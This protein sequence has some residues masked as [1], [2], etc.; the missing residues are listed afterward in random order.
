MVRPE[1]SFQ[2]SVL[3]FY[4]GFWGP[5]FA[6]QASTV[7]P[8]FY[9]L[10]HHTGLKQTSSALHDLFNQRDCGL[11]NRFQLFFSSN[12]FTAE[13][14]KNVFMENIVSEFKGVLLWG[15]TFFLTSKMEIILSS[16]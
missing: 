9:P 6:D 1:H 8:T 5:N 16:D 3:S 11:G 4:H 10:S 2:K 15:R 14:G 12:F 7:T 13:V